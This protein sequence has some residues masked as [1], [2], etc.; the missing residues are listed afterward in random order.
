M[1]ARHLTLIGLENDVKRTLSWTQS[2][3]LTGEVQGQFRFRLRWDAT[4]WEA[5]RLNL[6]P[7]DR[8]HYQ[9]YLA[10][11]IL[12]KLCPET[13]DFMESDVYTTEQIQ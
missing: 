8:P 4:Y 5:F 3:E 11:P 6:D 7:H 9:L 12:K 13:L 2:G 10:K 1:A